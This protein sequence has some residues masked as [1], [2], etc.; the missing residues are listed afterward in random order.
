MKISL[1]KDVYDVEMLQ[2]AGTVTHKHNIATWKMKRTCIGL[3]ELQI[4]RFGKSKG[5]EQVNIEY[6]CANYKNTGIKILE[7]QDHENMHVKSTFVTIK[8]EQTFYNQ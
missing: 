6:E 8:Y 5:N 1:C 2:S 4:L 7:I 3:H